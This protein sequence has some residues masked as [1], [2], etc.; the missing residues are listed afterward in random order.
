MPDEGI[1]KPS[2]PTSIHSALARLYR[3][4]VAAHASI[5]DI[6]HRTEQW[7][8]G[9]SLSTPEEIDNTRSGWCAAYTH[10]YMALE[11]CQIAADLI[12]WLFLYDDCY[13]EGR[14]CQTMMEVGE[15][16]VQL[17]RT[18]EISQSAEPFE[19]A[20]L[21]LRERLEALADARFLN[22]FANSLAKFHSGWLFELP[23]R[24]AGKPP[25]MFCYQRMRPWSIGLHTLFDLIEIPQGPPFEPAC[26]AFEE[27]RNSAALLCAYVNDMHS[28]AKERH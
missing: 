14:E 6:Q 22:R 9:F 26:D 25:P 21:D 27:L 7:A 4:P 10:H 17:L 1:A 18:G 3:E 20:L 19:Q 13:G 8:R 28:F 12:C 24:L 5:K 23:Y 11:T 2:G 16:H 15:R